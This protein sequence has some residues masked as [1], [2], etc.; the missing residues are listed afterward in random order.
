MKLESVEIGEILC[1]QMHSTLKA[2]ELYVKIIDKDDSFLYFDPVMVN[3]RMLDFSIT[4]RK[5]CCDV[6]LGKGKRIYCFKNIVIDDV[7]NNGIPMHHRI[8]TGYEGLVLNSKEY[9]KHI[10]NVPCA[11]NRGSHKGITEGLVRDVSSNGIT[12]IT[13]GLLEVGQEPVITL[14]FP[15]NYIFNGLVVQKCRVVRVVDSE[16]D[17][18]D[19]HEYKSKK[20]V[21]LEVINE[22]RQYQDLVQCLEREKLRRLRGTS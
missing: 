7:K 17:N 12:V 13:D 14:D 2:F 4:E 9:P 1:I 16:I 22:T 11:Y 3:G 5:N 18:K 19:Y 20:L 21:D 8:F 6:F 10:V 15:E